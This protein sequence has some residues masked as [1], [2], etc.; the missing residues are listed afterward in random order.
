MKNINAELVE[1]AQAC[2][3]RLMNA[4]YEF[5]DATAYVTSRNPSMSSDELRAFYDTHLEEAAQACK[6]WERI[7]VQPEQGEGRMVALRNV[8]KGEFVRRKEG[9]KTTYRKGEYDRSMK[10]YC[11]TDWEDNSRDIYIKA[12]KL[13]HVGF[14]F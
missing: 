12:D 6:A 9:A 4:G 10:A 14:T 2:L 1:Q 13:V 5:P 7:E 3:L 11:L 8:P